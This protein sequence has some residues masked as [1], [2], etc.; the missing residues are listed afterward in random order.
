[1]IGTLMPQRLA[2]Q[3]PLVRVANGDQ[4]L[5]VYARVLDDV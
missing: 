5:F 3:S 4:A 1:L 2:E